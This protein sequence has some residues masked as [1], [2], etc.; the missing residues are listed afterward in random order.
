MMK[1]QSEILHIRTKGAGF[2]REVV[3]IIKEVLGQQVQRN[4]DQWR[5]G[6]RPPRQNREWKP[7]K[8]FTRGGHRNNA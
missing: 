2:E 5:D 6:G 8:D 7:R 1:Q 3:T 4:L